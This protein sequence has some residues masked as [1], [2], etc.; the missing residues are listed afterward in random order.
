KLAHGR[1][2]MLFDGTLVDAEQ[3]RDVPRF[4]A[5]R[6]EPQRLPLAARERRF[7]TARRSVKEEKP[8]EGIKRHEMK[9]GDRPARELAV[10]AGKPNDALAQRAAE[11]RYHQSLQKSELGRAPNKRCRARLLLLIG[12]GL[13]PEERPAR[14]AAG[15][16]SRIDLAVFFSQVNFVPAFRQAFAQY[17]PVEVATVRPSVQEHEI[18]DIE[19]RQNAFERG[20]NFARAREPL[21]LFDK[22]ED[23]A[24]HRCACRDIRRMT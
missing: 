23:P 6:G 14:S 9:G 21:D 7:A 11:N 16:E 18:W 13:G 8:L 3:L 17:Q 1:L 4:V 22:R 5:V 2:E 12:R 10:G 24:I 20:G 19:G 15:G